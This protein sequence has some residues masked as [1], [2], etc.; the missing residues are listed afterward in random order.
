MR[1]LPNQVHPSR[2]EEGEWEIGEHV[3]HR[4][5]VYG[6]PSV[7]TC[8]YSSIG[9]RGIAIGQKAEP[10]AEI[11]QRIWGRI[12]RIEL[13]LRSIRSLKFANRPLETRR[14]AAT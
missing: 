11:C 10:T 5:H 3:A 9:G 6:T 7:T 14:Q 1:A 4:C 8:T 12:E 2:I 13:R